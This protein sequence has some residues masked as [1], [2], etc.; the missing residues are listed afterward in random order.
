MENDMKPDMKTPLRTTLG[1]A[2]AGALA[3]GLAAC[4]QQQKSQPLKFGK[5][6]E[7][8]PEKPA[9]GGAPAT[10][11]AAIDIP[12][13]GDASLA[14]KVKTAIAAEPDLKSV[15]VSVNAAGGVVTLNGTADTHATS[16]RAA[17]VALNVDGVRSVKN[18]LI[19]VRGS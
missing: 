5:N 8:T 11:S 14:T 4:D 15:T 18:E 13:P 19:V 7:I 1:V 2:L 16:D 10:G 3:V 9:G 12:D 6:F 17:R